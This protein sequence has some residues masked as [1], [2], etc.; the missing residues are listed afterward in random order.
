MYASY[1]DTDSPRKKCIVLKGLHGRC[2]HPLSCLDAHPTSPHPFTSWGNIRH[3]G[4][5]LNLQ[6]LGSWDRRIKRLRPACA[7]GIVLSLLFIQPR[8]LAHGWCSPNSVGVFFPQL[9]F[10]G[11]VLTNGLRDVSPR[12]L[13][14]LSSWQ[15]RLTTTGAPL[16]QNC[17]T[18][19][20]TA[21]NSS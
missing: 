5:C 2:P 1:L 17:P 21:L 11:N 12:W 14:I 13:Q 6:Y 4:T 7:Q 20:T 9:N 18:Q 10:S 3:G 19:R 16:G 15:W 8:M